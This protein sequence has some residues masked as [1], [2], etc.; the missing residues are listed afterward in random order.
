[1]YHLRDRPQPSPA[2]V[3]IAKAEL[4]H[5][6]QRFRLRLEHE[7]SG[8]PLTRQQ[9]LLLAQPPASRSSLFYGQ[10]RVPPST[11]APPQ[12]WFQNFSANSMTTTGH[13]PTTP[14]ANPSNAILSQIA[15][16]I[17][18]SNGW[19]GGNLLDPTSQWSMNNQAQAA[20]PAPMSM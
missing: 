6:E 13:D 1:V 5:L 11:L 9:E 2:E 16:A 20:A 8:V 12:S 14:L 7:Q 17:A 15:P 18:S 3:E 10:Q 4:N 19:A